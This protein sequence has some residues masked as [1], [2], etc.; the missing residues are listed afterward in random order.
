[1][2]VEV[3]DT[4]CEPAVSL[5]EAQRRV[6]LNLGYTCNNNCRFC[7]EAL[8]RKSKAGRALADSL[9]TSEILSQ[10]MTYFKLGFRHVTFLGG[11]PTLRADFVKLVAGAKKIGYQTIFLTTNGRRLA[12]SGFAD[13]LVKAGLSRVYLSMHGPDAPSHDYAVRAA[14]A[15]DQVNTGIENLRKMDTPFGIASV[16]YKANVSRLT[17][18]LRMQ[19]ETGA[20]RLFWAVVRPVGGARESFAELVPGFAEV[21]DGLHAALTSMPQAPLTVAH[22]PL[23]LMSGIEKHVDELYWTGAAVERE[24][25]KFVDLKDGTARREVVVTKGHYKT[26]RDRCL[27]CR[28][29]AIC[30]GVHAEYVRQRGFSE[31]ISVS[32]EPVT[33][34]ALLRDAALAVEES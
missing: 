11:E 4:A 19:L 25:D 15:F 29:V 30:Q 3:T 16:I 28:Y 31:F 8:M 6:E 27:D 33:D 14:G 9:T 2:A 22:M 13:K 20:D 10:L 1:M 23:C 32:G 26:K 34:P 7:S 5:H 18:M 21:S 17:E 12:D 24:V